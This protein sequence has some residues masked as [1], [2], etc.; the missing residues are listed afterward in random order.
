MFAL[1]VSLVANSPLVRTYGEWKDSAEISSTILH[2]L[3]QSFD[4]FP[5]DSTLHIF[6]LPDGISSYQTQ[7]PSIRTTGYLKDY[8]IK[9]WLD[10]TRP[11]NNVRVVVHSR[12][13]PAFNPRHLYLETTRGEG[14]DV[15][16]L[17][18]FD[19]RAA[20]P[21]DPPQAR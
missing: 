3:S 11:I 4:E 8:S 1:A 10:L 14:N 5:N 18:K 13:T 2:H 20:L 16:L 7:I 9:S 12:S 15:V 21:Q 17:V 19:D 6:N